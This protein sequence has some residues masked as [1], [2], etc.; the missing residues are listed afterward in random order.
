[1]LRETIS[2]L[3]CFLFYIIWF[4]F[5]IQTNKATL[6]GIIIA[7]VAIGIVQATLIFLNKIKHNLEPENQNWLILAQKKIRMALYAASGVA[8]FV[9]VDLS[10]ALL[11]SREATISAVR[12]NCHRTSNAPGRASVEL[13]SYNGKMCLKLSN[14]TGS[15]LYVS[16]EKVFRSVLIGEYANL[17]VEI[18]DS[19]IF[20]VET[21]ILSATIKK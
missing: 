4:V 14:K 10:M 21:Y 15:V 9:C 12:I 1:M 7:I 20:G 18:A 11:Q 16:E 13:E 19:Q 8:V 5:G 6:S 3:P 17:T 2:V